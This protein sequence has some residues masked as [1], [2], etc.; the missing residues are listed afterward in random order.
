MTTSS[1]DISA[2]RDQFPVFG[3]TLPNGSS[4]TFLDSAASA[5]KPKCVIDAERLVQETHYANA[6]RGVY[7]FGAQIDD[8]LEATR[9]TVRSLL[10]AEHTHEIIFTAGSTMSI[11]L[12]AHGWGI[13][14]LKPGDEILLNVMEHHANFVPWQQVAKKTG[15]KLVFIP[16]TEQGELD[17]DEFDKLVSERT[18][19]LAVCGMSNMLGTINPIQKLA[20]RVHEVGG[21][22]VVDGA[23]SVPHLPVDV[24]S[25]GIDFLAFSGH[26]IYGPSGVGLLYGRTELLENMDPSIFGGHMIDQVNLTESTWAPL[27]ARFEAGTPPIAQVVALKTAID[28]VNEIGFEAMHEHESLLTRTAIERL[29]EFP[30]TTIYGPHADQRGAIVSFTM[31]GAHP[32]DL[33]QLLDRKG[34]FI[35]HGHHCTMP[36]HNQLGIQASVRVSFGIYNTLEDIDRLIDAIHFARGR[37]RLE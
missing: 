34:V 22:V 17:L 16:L 35:R 10:H 36:L 9:E 28:F 23:Q 30:G 15:A 21:I 6:Y 5:Q 25:E 26:K 11:N 2:I 8:E 12:V 29:N 13:K 4:V 33:A 1:L 24:I 7:Q 3:E 20:E 19:I 31:Q 18:K 37:L 14:H 32:E 27:P